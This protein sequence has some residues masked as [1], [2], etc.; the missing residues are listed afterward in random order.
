[1]IAAVAAITCLAP[2]GARAALSAARIHLLSTAALKVKGRNAD[3][4][5][6]DMGDLIVQITLRRGGDAESCAGAVATA[7]QESTLRNLAG[8][9]R[10]SAGLF[11]QRP[12][13]GWGSYAQVTTPRY[14]INK[15]LNQYLHWRRKGYGWLEA[16]NKTQRSAYPNAPARWYREG[17][18]FTGRFAPPGVNGHAAR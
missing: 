1:V 14:A 9:D 15:F 13:M 6:L 16:A 7:I 8:G 12:S 5:Q 18:A 17:I 4:Q 3:A 10:D 11:Q 2:A